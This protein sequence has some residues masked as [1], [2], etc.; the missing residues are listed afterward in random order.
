MVPCPGDFVTT[1]MGE[2]PIIVTRDSSGS[3]HALLNTCRHRGNKICLFSRGNMDAFTCS[4]HGWQ[5]GNDGSLR[6]V[7]YLRGAYLDELDKNAFGLIRVPRLEVRSGLIFGTWNAQVG[8][9]EGTK[10]INFGSNEYFTSL[11]LA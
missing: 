10:S 9:L 3:I 5:Y 8:S 2:D 11:V 7:P 6:S 1:T 4:Y